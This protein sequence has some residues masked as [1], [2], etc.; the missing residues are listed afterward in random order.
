[1]GLDIT[2]EQR[3]ALRRA[4]LNGD[5]HLLLG[6]GSSLSSR[7]AA[8][9]ALPTSVQLCEMISKHFR[10]PFEDGDL[11]WRV[12]DRAV[13]EVGEQA[14]YE[15]LRLQFSSVT[16][17]DWM[18]VIA[19]TPWSAVWTLN[20]D[21]TFERA[22]DRVKT[23]TSRDLRVINW[24]D[25][26]KKDRT[27][28]IVHLHGCVD[29]RK[30]KKLVFSLSEYANVAV[31][32]SAWPIN[33]R[34]LYGVSPF[35][36]IGARLRDE[37]DI[38]AVVARRK[39]SHE[40]PSFYVS[41]NVSG[42]LERDLRSWGLIPVRMT[43][44]QFCEV[45]PELTGM[46]LDRPP[47]RNDELYIRLGHQFRELKL[48]PPPRVPRKQDFL[49]GDEPK[50][51]DITNDLYARLDWIRQAEADCQQLGK[52]IPFASALIY[53]GG[54][55]TG[56]SAGLYAIAKE[57]RTRSWRTFLFT[58]DERIDSDAVLRFA[59]D[60]KAIALLFDGVADFADDISY[61]IEEAR[62]SSLN[63]VCVGVEQEDRT[64]S[65]VGRI[66][67][68]FLINRQVR[69]INRKL[70]MADAGRLVDL[71]SAKGRLGILEEKRG[72]RQ[73]VAHFAGHELFDSMAQVENAPG[74]GK[75]VESLVRAVNSQAHLE[76]VF[77]AAFASRVGRRFHAADA[78]RMLGMDSDR[79]S[80]LVRSETP[81]NAL[82]TIDSP[83]IRTRHRWMALDE[84]IKRLGE[85]PALLLL[86][87]AMQ[88]LAPRLGRA[89]QRERN[90]TSMLVG[91]FMR[92]R[93]L[94]QLFPAADLDRWYE[95]LEIA[96]GSW[97][98][99]FWEQRAIMSRQKGASNPEI[100][101]RAES[102][103][104]RAT[105]I[106]RDAYS[107]TTLG[108]VL[109]AK[110]AFGTGIDVGEYYD[111]AI[112]AFEA[113]GADDPDNIVSWLAFLRGS[114]NILER[115][116]DEQEV[117]TELRDRL[118]EDWQ[119]IYAQIEAIADVGD[120]TRRDLAGLRNKYFSL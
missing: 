13:D 91:E 29:G 69:S 16:P 75:R 77:L 100:L 62:R 101:S 65:I 76:L 114:L 111:R 108:T 10:V 17:P 21:D 72:D 99:R 87:G 88:R 34:D 74:F 18:D 1:M 12:Y 37:P 52:T 5:Y 79:L 103:A 19:R 6:A 109:L 120:V 33:F 118:F 49:G 110:A 104:L 112:D 116:N 38:E 48:N 39:P 4:V 14:V 80:N 28:P 85:S 113:A 68:A 24:D 97:S 82:L 55:L 61:L 90:A 93:N 43:A 50:W 64:A 58:G 36:I 86:G 119:R 11:L 7:N 105:S 117:D 40:A 35:V 42:A 115:L 3:Q 106:V 27:L 47:T 95:S 89:S 54:R 23:E 81:T 56:R 41:P 51:A 20:L 30:P 60:G 83:W 25:E 92:Y 59:A 46:R 15:W 102:Y 26:Y 70:T 98:A 44:E 32:R 53:V 22:Y 66:D 78:S 45:W 31:S 107:L 8:G 63:I 67:S 71:L 9:A 96:F 57:L 2:G 94:S 73:R 84:S